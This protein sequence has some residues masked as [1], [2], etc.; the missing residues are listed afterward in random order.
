MKWFYFGMA[1]IFF[2]L[3]I[4]SMVKHESLALKCALFGVGL[5][6]SALWEIEKI[7]ER[8]DKE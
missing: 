8:I 1:F 3:T 5:G 7:K 6:F 2:A 4:T